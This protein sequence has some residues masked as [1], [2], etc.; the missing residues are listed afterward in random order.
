MYNNGE[1]KP[2]STYTY[3]YTRGYTMLNALTMTNNNSLAAREDIAHLYTRWL[4]FIEGSDKTVETYTRAVK[5]FVVYL[6][7]HGITEPNKD[8]VRAFREELKADHKPTTVQNYIM[9]LKQFFK[10][11]AEEGIYPN[12]AENVKGAKLDT[13]HKKDALTTRQVKAV[14]AGIDRSSVQ[15]KRDYAILTLM[16]TAGLRTIE[17]TRANIEDIRTVGDFTALFLQGKGHLERTQYVKLAPTVE[18]AIR[19]YLAARGK[20][21]AAEPLFTATS[22]RNEN[23]RLTTKSVSRLVKERLVSA[24]FDSDRLTAHSLRHTCATLNLLNG[25]TVEETQQLLRH[26]NINTTL[27]YS[28]ALE[29][30]QNNSECRVASAI[31]G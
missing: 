29:R 7:A 2:S 4:T 16:L 12:I 28:H 6:Q 26:T 9:A 17:V 21:D 8:D 19:E 1:G 15:G 14:L 31:F 11:T 13:E 20:T 22:N 25:G 3:S 30:A 23:G 24:G 18:D 10:W 27:I 5:Q